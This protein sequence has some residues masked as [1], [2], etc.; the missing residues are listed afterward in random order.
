MKRNTT[1]DNIESNQTEAIK[2][3]AA[4]C[5]RQAETWKRVTREAAI[6][7]L[8]AFIISITMPEGPA[9][10]PAF[11]LVNALLTISAV[12]RQTGPSTGSSSLSES[13]SLVKKSI[14]MGLPDTK[15]VLSWQGQISIIIADALLADNI[16]VVTLHSLYHVIEFIS[17]I[18]DVLKMFQM[19]ILF[20]LI[21]SLLCGFLGYKIGF[22]AATFL[23][24]FSHITE[25]LRLYRQYHSTT[26][27]LNGT[28]CHLL[29]SRKSHPLMQVYLTWFYST[30][31][32]IH[33]ISTKVETMASTNPRHISRSSIAVLRSSC[34]NPTSLAM[35]SG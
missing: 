19:R 12:L 13:G 30:P 28:V 25:N 2:N 24:R 9:A 10:L 33:H 32:I 17:V 1:K 15:F 3:V 21:N 4:I 11:I 20:W 23:P 31:F 26:M 8:A 34:F 16:A 7:S 29:S 27:S 22:F 18:V 5:Q 35:T 14:I 6:F